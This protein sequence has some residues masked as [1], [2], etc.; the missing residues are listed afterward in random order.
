MTWFAPYQKYILSAVKQKNI[1]NQFLDWERW[2]YLHH[3]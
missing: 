2:R 3:V 1:M